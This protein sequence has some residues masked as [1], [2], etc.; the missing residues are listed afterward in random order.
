MDARELFGQWLDLAPLNGRAAGLVR[1]RF[2]GEDKHPSLSVDLDR[3]LFHCFTCGI[4]GGV[5]RF[6]DAVNAPIPS[7]R[8]TTQPAAGGALSRAFDRARREGQWY[9]QWEPLFTLSDVV[10]R[11]YA[12]ADAARALGTALGPDHA[13]TWGLLEYAAKV[14]THGRAVESELDRLYGQGRLG[15]PARP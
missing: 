13:W 8:T 11:S 6:A 9:A 15:L 3:G 2:H 12:W 1:C 5:K 10:R 4:G 14:E 7:R